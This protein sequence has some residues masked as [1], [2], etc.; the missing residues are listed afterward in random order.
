MTKASEKACYV[1]NKEFS[2][3]VVDYCEKAEKAKKQKS[4]KRKEEVVTYI[5][6]CFL[7]IAE[8]FIT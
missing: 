7:K 8:G 2:L 6:E 5:A 4:K 3:A 1:N